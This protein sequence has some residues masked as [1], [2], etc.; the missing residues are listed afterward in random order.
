MRF[1]CIL[2][3]WNGSRANHEE[4]KS[5]VYGT[6]VDLVMVLQEEVVGKVNTRVILDVFVLL[7][8]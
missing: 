5:I 4:E 8:N 7:L 1:Y 2:K 6:R 3:N